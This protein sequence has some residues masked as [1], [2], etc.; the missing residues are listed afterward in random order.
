LVEYVK[1]IEIVEVLPCITT[2]GYIR[3]IAKADRR[4]DELIP[5]ICLMFPPGRVTYLKSENKLTLKVWNRLVTLHSDGTIA[6]TNTKDLE[7]AKEILN[8]I[9]K[10]IFEAYDEYL[11]KG[12]PS[13][14]EIS[15]ISRI[16]WLDIYQHL[17]K[18]N[19]G[20]CG[21]QVCSAFASS[22]LNG[23]VKLSACFPLKEP[24]YQQNL[25]KLKQ[26]LG[27]RLL[28]SLGWDEYC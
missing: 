9:K 28:K 19:C 25:R 26:I 13:E 6:V 8:R 2:P 12:K 10:I 24:Q 14:E 16:S 4:L 15:R 7:E 18:L 20:K 1:N 23:D 22:L 27:E 21:Y 17:P 3:F 11:R 5:I